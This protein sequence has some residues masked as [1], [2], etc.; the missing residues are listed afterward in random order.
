MSKDTHYKQGKTF[1]FPSIPREI[2]LTLGA[3]VLTAMSLWLLL[4]DI[5]LKLL[6]KVVILLG[7]PFFGLGTLVLLQNLLRHILFHRPSI[8]LREDSIMF[9]LPIRFKYQAIAFKNIKSLAITQVKKEKFISIYLKEQQKKRE[10][11]QGNRPG[12]NK[13]LRH[14]D[15]ILT[16]THLNISAN[17]LAISTGEL[18][19]MMQ[20]RLETWR[21]NQK[22]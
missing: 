9:Y 15:T 12:L 1:I 2:L 16:G 19:Q 21:E 20:Q 13:W 6:V 7:V 18:Y 5:Y 14:F 22:G 8:I 17:N 11:T 10:A 3:A 4:S